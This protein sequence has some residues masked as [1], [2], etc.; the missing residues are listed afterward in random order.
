MCWGTQLVGC[1]FFFLEWDHT[2]K[3]VSP[4]SL[5]DKGI[6]FKFLYGSPIHFS[7]LGVHLLHLSLIWQW[8]IFQIS[9]RVTALFSI[10]WSA[11][12]ASLSYLTMEYISNFSTGHLSIFCTLEFIF[13]ISYLFSISWSPS[14]S[15]IFSDNGI[16]VKFLYGSPIYF[17]YLRVRLL[18]VPY[19]TMEYIS[20][21]STGHLSMF[22][23][24]G[25]HLLHLPY[26]TMEYISNFSAVHLS[27]FHT[28]ESITCIYLI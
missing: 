27:I 15:S 18:H 20:N 26:L 10:L 23:Y 8:N 22:P 17:P 25:V 3:G 4:V 2:E 6:Y 14:P 19:L 11:S 28:L 16:Y 24:L 5:S 9:L 12:P 7:Y 13:S 1:G 21:F